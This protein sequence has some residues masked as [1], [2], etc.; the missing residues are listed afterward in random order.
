MRGACCSYLSLQGRLSQ[1]MKLKRAPCGASDLNLTN[2]DPY[3]LWGRDGRSPLSGRPSSGDAQHRPEAEAGVGVY[4]RGHRCSPPPDW[5]SA[6]HQRTGS[7]RLDPTRG[8]DKEE[9]R[10]PL[11]SYA[12]ALPSREG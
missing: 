4:T 6:S 9:M 8:R 11:V 1:M 2:C 5:P 10:Q 3:P 12:I 7:A